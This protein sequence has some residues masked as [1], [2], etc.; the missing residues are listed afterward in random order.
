MVSHI[1]IFT[2][3][4][5]ND[6]IWLTF[7]KE[8]E[9]TNMLMPWNTGIF[10][11]TRPARSSPAFNV[12]SNVATRYGV[13]LHRLERWYRPLP[14]G[15]PVMWGLSWTR[16]WQLKYLLIFTLPGE[17]FPFL[18]HTFQIKR[19]RQLVNHY[20]DPL[21]NNQDSMESKKVFLWLRWVE[22]VKTAQETQKHLKKPK[23][24]CT[25]MK[26]S[27]KLSQLILSKHVARENPQS[28]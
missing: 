18:T 1:Y 15:E 11:P 17:R 3:T 12:P 19:N 27:R 10:I 16:W 22:P 21:S 28:M 8:V 9:I 2:P 13:A 20:K 26:D 24:I 6:P 7:F 14:R 23:S 4:W 25:V 5:G